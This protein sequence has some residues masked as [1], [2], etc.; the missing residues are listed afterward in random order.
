MFTP[1]NKYE[2]LH[3]GRSK[4]KHQN[5]LE[6]DEMGSGKKLGLMVDTKLVWAS[7]VS[8]GTGAQQSLELHQQNFASGLREGS[9]LLCSVL[10]GPG[11]PC[12]LLGFPV[13]DMGV[14]EGGQQITTRWK[15][16]SIKMR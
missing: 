8:F 10:V 3:L 1:G 15:D 5:I 13:Q 12:P 2:V 6:S 14:V 4:S 16:C 11:G 7:S 9:P